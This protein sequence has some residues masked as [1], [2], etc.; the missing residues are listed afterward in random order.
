MGLLTCIVNTFVCLARN[1]MDFRGQKLAFL[2][3]NIIFTISTIASIGISYHKQDLALGTYI[4]L[5]GSALST[6]LVVP[7]WPIYNRHPIKWEESPTTKHKK[8]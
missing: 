2:I 7:T 3:K 6:L 5:A 1:Q 8:K 4:I